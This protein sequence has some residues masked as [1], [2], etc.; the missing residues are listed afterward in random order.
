MI[1]EKEILPNVFILREPVSFLRGL[2]VDGGYAVCC[3]KP[4][5]RDV[6]S[7]VLHRKVWVCQH[8]W[9]PTIHLTTTDPW[10][11]VRKMSGDGLFTQRSMK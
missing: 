11:Y 10:K 3:W 6:I 5:F 7:I 9:S 1:K 4:R 8:G 2:P